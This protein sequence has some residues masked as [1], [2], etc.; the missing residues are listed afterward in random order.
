MII[1]CHVHIA[2]QFTG[3]W[4]PLRYGKTEEDGVVRQTLPPSFDPVASPPEILL[5]YMDLAEVDKAVMVQHHLYGDQNRVVLD[6]LKRWPDRFVGFAY[7]GAMD[8]PDA[9]DQLERLIEGGMAGLKIELGVTR[10]Q[11][12][13]FRFDGEREGRVWERLNQLHRPVILDL[14]EATPADTLALRQVIAAYPQMPIAICHL[15]GVPSPG[16]EE[17]ALLAKEPNVY[18]DVVSLPAMLDPDEDYPFPQ[19]QQAVRWAVDNLG[20]GKVMWGTDY[21][22]LLNWGTYPQLLDW[23][24]RHCEFLT[25]AQRQELLSGTVQRFLQR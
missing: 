19:A 17:R 9:P 4:K 6:T 14:N 11:R 3:F 12:A 24:R 10:R 2:R 5:G 23:V 22:G 21:P 13:D 8:Q 25:A 18:V 20:A 15:G 16:W 1:D 7:L